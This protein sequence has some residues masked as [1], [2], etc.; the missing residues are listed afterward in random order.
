MFETIFVFKILIPALIAFATGMAITPVL[1][2]YFFKYR[3][4]K[5]SSRTSEENTS[6]KFAIDQNLKDI[7]NEAETKTPRVGGMIVWLSVVL[8]I[9]VTGLISTFFNFT[10]ELEALDLRFLS[11]SQTLIPF[12][13]LLVGALIGL[14]DDFLQIFGSTVT[15]LTQGIPRK[16]RI[17]LVTLLGLVEGYWFFEKLGYSSLDI[18]FSNLDLQLGAF[19]IV[20]YALV[21]LALFSSSV[22]DGIDGL[23]GGILSVIFTIYGII[24]IIQ[25]QFDIATFCFVVTGGLLA[26]LWFN[27]PPARFYLGETGIL[28][29]TLC[30]SVIIFLTET[31]FEFLVIGFP[32][33]IT[34]LSSFLQIIWRRK[35]N[36]KLFRVAPLHHHFESKGWS[37]SKITMRYWVF[38]VMCGALGLV[39]VI[40]G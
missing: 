21:V 29:L 8:T 37:R 5:R 3:I 35:F 23:A 20:F 36:K 9:C 25:G 2:H 32:L 34:S 1:T 6:G 33:V 15:Q 11:R 17:A 14:A 18:P 26:F 22:I 28:A 12:A 39:I 40:V 7:H 13:S 30:L 27:I 16:V 10:G 31:V 24:G 19:F 4:W 38:T